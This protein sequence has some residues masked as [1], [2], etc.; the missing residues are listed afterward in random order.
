MVKYFAIFVVIFSALIMSVEA[1]TWIEVGEKLYIDRDSIEYT[2]TYSGQQQATFWTKELNDGS[3]VFKKLEKRYNKKVW[4]TLNRQLIN[5]DKKEIGITDS[6]DYD[7][8]REYIET[9]Y[10]GSNSLS[11]I[12]PESYGEYLYKIVCFAE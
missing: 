4:Y 5:C 6:I 12:V 8:K 10:F 7:L 9:Y 1:A 3:D 11:A 2:K